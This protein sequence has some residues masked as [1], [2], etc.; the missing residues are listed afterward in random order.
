MHHI[1][2]S[3]SLHQTSNFCTTTQL[4]L[5]IFVPPAS[6]Y[7]GRKLY[8]L[9]YGSSCLCRVLLS[10]PILHLIKYTLSH[11]SFMSTAAF[12]C[13]PFC[14]LFLYL[15]WSSIFIYLIRDPLADWR[16]S[17]EHVGNA[18]CTRYPKISNTNQYP[19]VGVIESA[20][21][22]SATISLLGRKT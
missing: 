11:S 13:P 8:P 6:S 15:L 21:Q 12:A 1:F 4:T 5:Y 22:W 20:H 10:S 2:F 14:I 7:F 16:D 17:C 3:C 19:L 9:N 18:M